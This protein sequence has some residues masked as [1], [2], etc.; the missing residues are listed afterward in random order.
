MRFVIKTVNNTRV[1]FSW[2]WKDDNDEFQPYDLKTTAL[3]EDMVVGDTVSTLLFLTH[4]MHMCMCIEISFIRD[5]FNYTIRKNSVESAVQLNKN[6]KK[7]REIT[8]T[9]TRIDLSEIATP[10]HWRFEADIHRTNFVDLSIDDQ[11]YELIRSN[12]FET[13]DPS[14]F[15][16][17]GTLDRPPVDLSCRE[18]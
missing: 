13:V 15:N 4:S 9:E 6:T 1:E 12:F 17:K 3:I 5:P 16:I 11:T 18:V 14:R 7:R 2:K 8:R 10:N